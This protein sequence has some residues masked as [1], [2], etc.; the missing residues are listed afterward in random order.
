MRGTFRPA[1][2]WQRARCD[3]QSPAFHHR[4]RDVP[5]IVVS[6]SFVAN[7]VAPVERG[8]HRGHDPLLLD[9]RPVTDRPLILL[10]NDDG[11]NARGLR[12]LRDALVVLGRVI[13]VAPTSEQSASSHALTLHRPLRHRVVDEDVHS[14]DGSPADS[15]YV[16]LYRADLLPRWPDLVVSGIN[17]GYNLGT[18]VY[19]SGTVAAA[20]EAAL[21][22]VPAMAI[23][24]LPI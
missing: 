20:R 12:A 24:L 14:V 16:A 1:L 5:G 8:G 11:V 7:R 19:Y 22:G 10:S 18:D 9:T 21:R 13:V 15:V 17:R 2:G 23:C 6:R 3:P 4:A